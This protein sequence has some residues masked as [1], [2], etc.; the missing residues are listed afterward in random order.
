MKYEKATAKIILF[1][2]SD[3]ITASGNKCHNVNGNKP[4]QNCSSNK[5]PGFK[6]DKSG[7][8]GTTPTN[9]YSTYWSGW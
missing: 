3:V 2:N 5:N 8:D 4:H 9:T 7:G 6:Y 1:S